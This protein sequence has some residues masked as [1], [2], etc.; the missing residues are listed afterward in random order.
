M[1]MTT[2]PPQQQSTTGANATATTTTTRKTTALRI[3]AWMVKYEQLCEFHKSHGHC[4]VPK[5]APLLGNWVQG[6]RQ[7]YRYLQAGRHHQLNTERLACLNRIGFFADRVPPTVPTRTTLDNAIWLARYTD[8]LEYQQVHGD[9]HVPRNNAADPSLARWV[10]IQRKLYQR[11]QAAGRITNRLSKTRIQRLEKVGFIWSDDDNS[12]SNEINAQ[13]PPPQPPQQPPQQPAQPLPQP[14]P[15][16]PQPP[17]PPCREKKSSILMECFM[18]WGLV[19][20][21][22]K[23]F[24][25][26]RGE[27]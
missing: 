18:E 8:L 15:Q 4:R 20:K 14:L 13:Q 7:E 19:V 23:P 24:E 22:G 27:T 21:E 17:Q 9:C 26:Q 25:Q 11:S 2:L 5:S 1:M 12:S 10:Q 16:P 6:Q 3:A